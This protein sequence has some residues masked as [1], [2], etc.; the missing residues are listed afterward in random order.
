MGTN[1]HTQQGEGGKGTGA[2]GRTA[3]MTSLAKQP[4]YLPAPLKHTQMQ[5]E[6][7]RPTETACDAT[8]WLRTQTPPGVRNT[9]VVLT[10]STFGIGS[11]WNE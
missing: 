3:L 8:L 11:E 6:V 1:T 7:K 5:P 2:L 9:L 4:P 10:V